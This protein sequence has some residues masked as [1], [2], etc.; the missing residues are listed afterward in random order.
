MKRSHADSQNHHRTRANRELWCMNLGEVRYAVGGIIPEGACLLAGAPKLGKSWLA[1][2]IALAAAEGG[3][4][5]GM[6]PVE[7]GPVLYLA[8]EDRPRR[9]QSRP[10]KLLG[11]AGQ[12]PPEGREFAVAWP[13]TN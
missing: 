8:L 13:R 5:L 3:V 11:P 12:D 9:L 7:Q 2:N 1:L 6:V 10:R 4:A